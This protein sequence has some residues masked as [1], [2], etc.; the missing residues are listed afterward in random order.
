VTRIEYS[1]PQTNLLFQD[2]EF[3]YRVSDSI[4]EI[5]DETQIYLPRSPV[6]GLNLLP[7]P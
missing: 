1:D 2:S 7:S 4:D 5:K 6:A 3:Q